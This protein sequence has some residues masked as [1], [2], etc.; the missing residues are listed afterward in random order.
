[1]PADHVF[2]L[3]RWPAL[4]RIEHVAAWFR[5]QANLRLAPRTLTAYAPGLTDFVETCDA[6]GVDP[7]AADRTVVAE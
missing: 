7:V 2:E 5:I 1:M 6:L 4:A 3:A